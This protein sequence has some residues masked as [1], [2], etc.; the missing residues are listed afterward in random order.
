MESLIEDAILVSDEVNTQDSISPTDASIPTY[1]SIDEVPLADGTLIIGCKIGTIVESV[2]T[3]EQTRILTVILKTK[4][5]GSYVHSFV[6]TVDSVKEYW[7]KDRLDKMEPF[8]DLE[9]EESTSSTVQNDE[10]LTPSITGQRGIPSRSTTG[11]RK[12]RGV[13][14][15]HEA[16]NVLRGLANAKAKN[17][18]RNKASAKSRKKNKK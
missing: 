13:A 17:R 14:T 4:D 7:D 16:T 2:H 11:F 8:I 5:F 3:D 1:T 9:L 18:A 15:M 10:N 12:Q 6:E